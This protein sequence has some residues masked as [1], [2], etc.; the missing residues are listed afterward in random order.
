VDLISVN[1]HKIHGPKGIGALI[2]RRRDGNRPPLEPIIHGGGHELGL[3]SGTLPA[4][5][6]AGFGLAVELAI[7][8]RDERA[9]ACKRMRSRLLEML[10]PFAPILHGNESASMP[11]VL[12]VSFPGI[13]ADDVVEALSP[14]VAIS[15]GAACTTQ[16]V[17]CSHVLGA[18]GCNADDV[19]GA[20]RWSWC[21]LT[22]EPDWA[23]ITAALRE[24]TRDVDRRATHTERALPRGTGG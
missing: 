12:N 6:I 7:T 17:T 8:E 2:A 11:H 15:T 23:G 5:L 4:H 16:S 22:P 20:I 18:M 9:T 19:A 3:R 10:D 1:A 14:Y 21:H 13:D 24:P